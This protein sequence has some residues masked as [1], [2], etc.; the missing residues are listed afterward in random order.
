MNEMKTIGGED[1]RSSVLKSHDRPTKILLVEDNED[2]IEVVREYLQF[3]KYEVIVARTGAEALERVQ[4]IYPN[5]IL[6]DI[7]LPEVDGL[8][9]IRRLRTSNNFAK[10]AIIALTALAM[11][12][13]RE[14]CLKA[15]ADAYLSKPI[16]LQE[17]VATIEKISGAKSS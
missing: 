6:M 11:E 12:G 14:I 13:D 8:E 2:N 17:L 5:L 9:A 4:E 15:G 10:I 7:H 16:K 1:K 3:N